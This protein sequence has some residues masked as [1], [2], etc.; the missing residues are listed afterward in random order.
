MYTIRN[1]SMLAIFSALLLCACSK[2]ES[3]TSTTSI[4]TTDYKGTGSVTSGTTSATTANLFAPGQRVAALGSITSTDNKAWTVPASVNYTDASF[5]FASD[6]HNTYVSGHSYSSAASAVAALPGSD[7]V[8]IDADGAVYTTYIWADNYFELYVNGKPV[9][10]DPVPYTDFNACIVRFKVKKPFTIA[11]KC[12][13]WE[14]SLG[15]GTEANGGSDYHIGDGGFVA[16]VKNDA[17]ATVAVTNNTWKAQTYYIAPIADLGCLTENGN[18]RLSATCATSGGSAKSYG[19]HWAE[20]NEWYNAAYDDSG[21]PAAVTF[22]N[23]TV[24]VGNKPS[25]SNFADVFD[26]SA[27]DASFIWSSNLLLDNVV[28]IR[29]K[30]E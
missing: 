18:S 19:I 4:N 11:V 27:N 28:L 14:E 9:G 7:I 20:P 2:K 17:G 29:K 5:P 10:K 3:T 6:M 22:D 16:V 8:T 24:G 25:Y 13:D 21:W 23:N 26:N 12:V 15:M 30:I 1:I